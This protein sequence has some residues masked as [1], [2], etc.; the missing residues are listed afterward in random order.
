MCIRDRVSA[1]VRLVSVQY[2]Q[3]LFSEDNSHFLAFES[4]TI[5]QD[6]P[7]YIVS[8]EVHYV[9]QLHAAAIIPEHEQVARLGK[10]LISRQINIPY[11]Q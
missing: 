1:V 3:S 2:R 6:I 11:L 7:A 5:F 8:S 10:L 4:A 9:D